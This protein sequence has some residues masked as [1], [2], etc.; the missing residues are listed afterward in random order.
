MKAERDPT[1]GCILTRKEAAILVITIDSLAKLNGFSAVMLVKYRG[2]LRRWRA[3][4][5][6]GAGFSAPT[7]GTS[8]PGSN[9]ASFPGVLRRQVA[10]F[11]R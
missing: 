8:L 9:S 1:D 6:S 3:I 11:S 10:V 7:A 4:P 5:P 2:R